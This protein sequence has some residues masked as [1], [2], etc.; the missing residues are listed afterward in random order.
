MLLFEGGNGE[1]MT[2]I[3]ALIIKT[4]P[5][6]YSCSYFDNGKYRFYIGTLEKTPSGCERVRP[7]LTSNAIYDS[8]EEAVND[9]NRIIKEIKETDYDTYCN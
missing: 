4:D 1:L 7:L 5:K 2:L 8:S 6:V 3:T 9:A